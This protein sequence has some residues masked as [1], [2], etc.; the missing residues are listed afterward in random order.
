[1]KVNELISN[2]IHV[3][4]GYKL[5]EGNLFVHPNDDVNK[6]QS[7]NDTFPTAMH[8]A[9]Y[10]MVI[11]T[12]LPGIAVLRDTLK[13]KSQEFK[14]AVKTDQT[15]F[16]DATPLILGQDFSGYAKQQL[17]N[18]IRVLKNG[19]EM[20]RELALGGTAVST[21]LNKT[22]RYDVLVAQKITEIT[23]FTFITA[24]NRFES[25]IAH[26]AMLELSGAITHCTV[27]LMKNRK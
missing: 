26:D 15:H 18:S 21:G 1:M 22:K 17:T 7:S 14:A 3:I 12:T 4:Q 6:S 24:P 25:L 20:I 16:V 11:E 9:A 2:R 13:S 27:S 10:T 8:I 5:G 19:L 23:I